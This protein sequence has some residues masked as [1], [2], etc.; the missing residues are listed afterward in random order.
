MERGNAAVRYAAVFIS[1]PLE[2][3]FVVMAVTD[4]DVVS[5]VHR[6]K[7]WRRMRGGIWVSILWS[8]RWIKNED[9]GVN[10]RW[11]AWFRRHFV[12]EY[13]GKV[14]FDCIPFFGK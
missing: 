3:I 4:G 8:T 2:L 14:V 6:G 10:C 5:C 9:M 12:V 13:R 11:S 1:S 7:S